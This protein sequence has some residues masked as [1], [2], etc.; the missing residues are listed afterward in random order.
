[1]LE[2]I[3]TPGASIVPY[4]SPPFA[5]ALA[6]GAASAN[7][8][9]DRFPDLAPREIAHE[10]GVPIEA[11]DDDQW[12]ARS[13][14]LPNIASGRPAFCFTAAD[15]HRSSRGCRSFSRAIARAATP[16]DVFIAHEL[17]HHT[18][19]I[20]PD[21]PIARRYSR[22]YFELAAG[23]GG[24]ASQALS[25]IAA[26]A[27]AAVAPRSACHPKVLDL[28]AVECHF[29]NAAATRIAARIARGKRMRMVTP[30]GLSLRFHLSSAAGCADNEEMAGA[31]DL[32]TPHI[33]AGFFG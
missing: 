29:T 28:V 19:A 6:D 20:R 7:A 14:D 24:P 15:S 21:M 9:R 26:G 22:H 13:G 3:P 27:F 2:A 33:A 32:S 5:T 30:A 8:L 12:S 17:Y 4:S 18:E 10:L 1:M 16:Q 31:L 25:E 11:T 23:A